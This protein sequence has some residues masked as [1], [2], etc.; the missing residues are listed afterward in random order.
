M[1]L[2]IRLR[3]SWSCTPR[4]IYIYIY[5]TYPCLASE[6]FSWNFRVSTTSGDA[7]NLSSPSSNHP[8]TKHE[9]IKKLFWKHYG[10]LLYLGDEIL[11]IYVG[12][13]VN[14]VIRISIKPTRI[15][16][17]ERQTVGWNFNVRSEPRLVPVHIQKDSWQMFCFSI[18]H[19]NQHHRTYGEKSHHRTYG[20]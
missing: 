9:P 18:H 6:E 12:I 11:P 5:V 7:W 2:G 8:R 3:L 19:R 20:I 1:A 17:K 4:V 14:S 15:Q 16:W 10:C 13:V